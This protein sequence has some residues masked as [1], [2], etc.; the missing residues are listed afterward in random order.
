MY[1]I[2]KH[3]DTAGLLD[4]SLD[5]LKRLIDIA[6]SEISVLST[7]SNPEEI[8]E[9]YLEIFEH[10]FQCFEQSM[11]K[12]IQS[13]LMNKESWNAMHTILKWQELFCERI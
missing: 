4:D 3:A 6:E 2:Y 13:I 9:K 10:E 7:A 12:F 1:D 11:F 8:K 5:L